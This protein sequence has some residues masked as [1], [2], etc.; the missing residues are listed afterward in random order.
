[1]RSNLE[2]AVELHPS[3]TDVEEREE[4]VETA[5]IANQTPANFSMRFSQRR[6]R[7]R[8]RRLEQVP[9]DVEPHRLRQVPTQIKRRE[10]VEVL[11]DVTN[12]R[13]VERR[14]TPFHF[15]GLYFFLLQS[16]TTHEIQV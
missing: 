14:W 2:H 15:F 3:M 5:K 1:M 16:V 6:R 11:G 9:V 10:S 4:N 8:R 12:R 13:H 7:R